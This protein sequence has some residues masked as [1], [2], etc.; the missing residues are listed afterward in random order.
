MSR[1]PLLAALAASVAVAAPVPKEIKNARP[2]LDGTWEVVEYH[3][4]GRLMNNATPVK[5]VIEGEKI[6]ILR[7]NV[8]AKTRISYSLEK[9]D[10]GADDHLDYVLTYPQADREKKVNPGVFEL[11]GD[12]LRFCWSTRGERPAEC[13]PD[14]NNLMYLFKRVEADK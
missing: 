7:N 2:P 12:T 3:S 9:P 1:L 14:Q 11:D 8:A 13:K 10:G 6:T 5:W 4:R